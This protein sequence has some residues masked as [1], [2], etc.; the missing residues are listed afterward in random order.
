M[1]FGHPFSSIDKLAAAEEENKIY[2]KIA[3]DIDKNIIDKGIWTKAFSKSEGNL[4]KQKAIY[5]ELMFQHYKKKQDAEKEIEKVEKAKRAVAAAKSAMEA[6]KNYHY[7][8][9][10]NYTDQLKR[11]K[12]KFK[13]EQREFEKK[14]K[15][16]K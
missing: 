1:K 4:D 13:Q 14:L 11:E 3:N 7:A 8:Q 9:A 2:E 5:I 16:G 6:E 15:E 12:E 10:R